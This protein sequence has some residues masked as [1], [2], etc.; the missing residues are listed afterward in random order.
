MS[1]IQKLL[2]STTE[3][4]PKDPKESQIEQSTDSQQQ[5]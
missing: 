5:L 3:F 1:D 4:D 2:E